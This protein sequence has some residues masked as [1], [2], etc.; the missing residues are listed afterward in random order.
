MNPLVPREDFPILSRSVHGRRLVY[1]DSAATAQ[2]PAPVIAAVDHFYRYTNANVLRSAHALADEATEA[3]EAARVKV[4][5]FIGAAS[6]AEV[7]FT[8]GTTESLNGI[9]RGWGDKF[10]GPGDEIVL[11]P[12]E[13]H[14]NLI[15]WQQLARR[16]EARLRFIELT[17]DGRITLEAAQAVI[18]PRTRLVALSAVSN[19]LGTINPIPEVAALAH[20]VGAVMVVDGAQSVPHEPTDVAALGADFLAFSG[21]KL[22]GPTGIGVLWGRET[23][24]DAMD[25]FL[26]GGEMIA[27]VDREHATW[28]DLPHKFEAGTPHIAGAVGLGAAL[29]YLQAVGMARVRDHGRA[30]G[31]EAYRRLAE[32]GV[33]VYGPAAPRAALVAF[34]LGPI[35]PHD[36]AQVFDAEGVAIRAGHHC[37]QPLMQWLGVAATARASFY[38]YNGSDDIDALLHAVEVTKRYF[39][40]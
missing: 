7:V 26:F 23:L 2:K 37:A 20:Q 35:H 24:L 10:V 16:R 40:R 3:Y 8:R 34:N 13:H 5:R 17:P 33:Q 29:D 12:M 25:P 14:A 6:P 30:L 1:L 22:G 27:Y 32:A 15:P 31:E 28:A 4:A 11:S 21:H 9:A 38:I 36:V 18:G 19:V 39:R